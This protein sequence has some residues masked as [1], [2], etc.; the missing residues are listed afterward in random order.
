MTSRLV[1]WQNNSSLMLIGIMQHE[2]KVCR[3]LVELQCQDGVDEVAE[4]ALLARPTFGGLWSQ[5]Y[6]K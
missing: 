1:K 3:Y 5:N 2:W 6:L 4:L